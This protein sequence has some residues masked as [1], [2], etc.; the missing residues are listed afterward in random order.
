MDALGS[1]A[2]ALV[3]GIASLSEG[4]AKFVPDILVTGGGNGGSALDGLAATAMRFF[5]GG[6]GKQA[7]TI[8]IPPVSAVPESPT[9]AAGEPSPPKKAK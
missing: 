5:N 4:K 7:A 8:A 3:N 9:Q 2:T 6:N 1:N